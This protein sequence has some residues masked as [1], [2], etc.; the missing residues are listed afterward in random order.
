M[1]L[2][3]ISVLLFVTSYKSVMSLD[4]TLLH[5]NDVHAHV[6]QSNKYGSA[7]SEQKAL[8]NKCY[9]G[10]ARLYTQI[11][12]ERNRKP[13]VLLLD[14]GDQFQVKKQHRNSYSIITLKVLFTSLSVYFIIVYGKQD[15]L[16]NE[17]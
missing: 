2:S 13:N 7:C 6:Q 12:T 5:T 8:D 10:A 11:Q 1:S 9:G 16:I 15:N 4:L 3:L 17:L 14:A